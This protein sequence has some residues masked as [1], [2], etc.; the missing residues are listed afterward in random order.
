MIVRLRFNAI[1]FIFFI[2]TCSVCSANP[3]KKNYE[4]GI[5]LYSQKNYKAAIKKLE[6]VLELYPDLPQ[7]YNY[8]GLAHKES[9]GDPDEII[10]LFKKA[11]E[12]DPK[13]SE[14]MEHLCKVYYAE[15]DFENAIYYGEKAIEIDPRQL[16]T[17]LALAWIYLLGEQ[18]PDEAIEH[19]KFVTNAHPIPYAI[20][21][22]GL[23]YFMNDERAQVIDMITQLKAIN[24]N[25]FADSL[26]T[27]LRQGYFDPHNSFVMP[28]LPPPKKKESVAVDDIQNMSGA[29][30]RVRLRSNPRKRPATNASSTSSNTSNWFNPPS[31]NGMTG[32]QRL[33]ELQKSSPNSRR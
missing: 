12:L 6:K 15:G 11:I 29:E 10:Y 16:S 17:R 24:E 7:A 20:F 2:I 18:A 25:D 13:Y 23:A 14:A 19:F 1:L 4:D 27:M 26:E 5:K 28:L 31:G 3:V 30:L 22:L 21:G 32:E 8:L 9:G 33:R